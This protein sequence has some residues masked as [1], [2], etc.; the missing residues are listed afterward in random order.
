[1]FGEIPKDVLQFTE[2]K[3]LTIGFNQIKTIPNWIVELEK[4]ES[5]AVN[6]NE[7]T[8]LNEYLLKLPNLK[9]LLIRENNFDKTKIKEIVKPYEN[10]GI[11]VQYE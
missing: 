9:Y 6:G 1:M 2:L 11:T 4:L 5:L 3:K 7:L 10:K 8:E